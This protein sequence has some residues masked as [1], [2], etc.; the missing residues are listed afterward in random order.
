MARPSRLRVGVEVEGL[1]EALATIDGIGNR[2]YQTTPLMSMIVQHLAG[3]SR[4]RVE[5]EKPWKPL[6]PGTMA[7]KSA[8][9]EDTGI[10]RDEWRPIAG[11]PTRQGDML[12]RALTQDG[13]PGQLRHWTRTFAQFGVKSAGQGELFYARFVQN[14]HGTKRKILAIKP[15]QAVEIGGMVARYIGHGHDFA[16][17]NTA[18]VNKRNPG[19]P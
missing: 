17:T 7:R 12:Y 9:G 10:L 3:I 5:G 4:E 1:N 16:G 15:D 11:T 18:Y 2:A 13:A 6:T 14:V 8:Q 19:G